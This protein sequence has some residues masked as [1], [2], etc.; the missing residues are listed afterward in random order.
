[1]NPVVHRSSQQPPPQ[2]PSRGGLDRPTARRPSRSE[3]ILTSPQFA[4]LQ[5]P[6]ST[7]KAGPYAATARRTASRRGRTPPVLM[8]WT[9]WMSRMTAHGRDTALRQRAWASAP[10]EPRAVM[11]GFAQGLRGDEGVPRQRHRA[12]ARRHGHGLPPDRGHGQHRVRLERLEER[13]G[14]GRPEGRG[15][16]DRS[17]RDAE[18]KSCRRRSRRDGSRNPTARQRSRPYP[19]ATRRTGQR[20]WGPRRPGGRGP[21]MP[22]RR[23]RRKT[24]SYPSPT[25]R[26][27]IAPLRLP[28]WQMTWTGCP[29]GIEPSIDLIRLIGARTAPGT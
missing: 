24:A 23:R 8:G 6:R 13:P 1:M 17:G 22:M 7:R 18:H 21:T 3:E 29:S 12:V 15:G 14:A 5:S 9:G 25:S 28:L 4:E 26:S 16:Q 19:A 11:D 10:S 27:A 20:A 2:E